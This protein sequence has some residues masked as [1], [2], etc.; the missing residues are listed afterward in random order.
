[1]PSLYIARFILGVAC[2]AATVATPLYNEEIAE[3]R[4]RGALGVNM[5]IM[6]NAGILYVYVIG[7]LDSYLWLS[8]S[9]CI[10]PAIFAVTFFW[11]PESPMFLVSKGEIDKAETSLRWLRGLD[12]EKGLCIERELNRMKDFVSDSFSKKTTQ[13]TKDTKR[14]TLKV[15]IADLSVTTPKAKAVRIILGLMTFQQLTGIDAVIYYSVDIFNDAGSSLSSSV[16]TI[17][18]GMLQLISTYITS[19]IIDRSGRRILLILSEL[20]M[21][22]SLLAMSLHFTMQNNAVEVLWSGWIPLVALNVYIAAFSIGF[23]PLPWLI[24]A[25]LLSTEAKVWVSAM[26]VCFNWSLTFA[27][28]KLFPVVNYHLGPAITYG[29][30]C[31]ICVLGFAFVV[32]FVPETQ[33]KTREDIQL[34]LLA[35]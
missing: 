12:K 33:G 1:M 32:V 25:E 4:I 9:A 13:V 20:G 8:I 16:C 15:R 14:G 35:V 5:D 27:V 34:Q 11:M 29:G 7:A 19:I 3:V 18:V 10:I 28:T 22:V 23:G 31:F 26:A 24:M 21:A 17:I 2:G 6:F 30:F